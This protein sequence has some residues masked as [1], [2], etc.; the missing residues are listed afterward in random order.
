LKIHNRKSYRLRKIRSLRFEPTDHC[1]VATDFVQ[2]FL[3]SS[4]RPREPILARRHHP[5]WTT[6]PALTE[7][8][9]R[10]RLTRGFTHSPSTIRT[11][12]P[13]G[14]GF[15]QTLLG[16]SKKARRL[17]MLHA[18]EVS[19]KGLDEVCVRDPNPC[20]QH[21]DDTTTK[22]PEAAGKPQPSERGELT[23]R[24]PLVGK[25]GAGSGCGGEFA[26]APH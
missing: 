12:L 8:K 5:T 26:R 20:Y 19:K 11:G 14:E 16:Q 2:E 6:S 23:S 7:N 25:E 22:S 17:L 10:R 15:E 18:G 4:F 24:L 1:G 21:H 13:G 9:A 3:F